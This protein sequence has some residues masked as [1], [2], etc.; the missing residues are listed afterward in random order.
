MSEHKDAAFYLANPDELAG[1]SA[2]E[3]EALAYPGEATGAAQDDTAQADPAPSGDAVATKEAGEQPQPDAILAR[4]GKHLIPISVLDAARKDA[5]NA[6]AAA[7]T[8]AEAR[9]AAEQ[10]L[11]ELQA[12]VDAMQS[13][14]GKAVEGVSVLSAE[15]LAQMEEDFPTLAKGFQVMQAEIARLQALSA[16]QETAKQ[17]TEIDTVARTVQD[18]I[19]SNPKL[20]H[21]QT[22]DP[23]GWAKA[24]AIDDGL[25]AAMPGTDMASRFNAVVA[26]YEAQ[27]GAV[28][29]PAKTETT[30]QETHKQPVKNQNVP[31]S[32]SQI[33]GGTPPAVSEAA[34][35]LAMN[36]TQALAHFDGMT[37]EQIERQLDSML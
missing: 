27:Y 24:V 30:S 28:V 23:T 4:D 14:D 1:L 3:L 36:G 7:N 13:G 12:K 5:T 11:A 10:R 26:A 16:R 9:V 32:M 31:L 33:P 35:L 8:E 20:S 19:D 18:L 34:A 22:T 2:D 15:E 25:R 17:E 37:K 21:L 29:A 6:Q